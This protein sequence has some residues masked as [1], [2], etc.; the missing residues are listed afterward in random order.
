MCNACGESLFHLSIPSSYYAA[1]ARIQIGV[2]CM[3][4]QNLTGGYLG[5]PT[6]QSYYF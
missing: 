6:S 2:I 3:F 5:E 4:T 1:A